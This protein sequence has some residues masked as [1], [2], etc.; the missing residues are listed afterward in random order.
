[1]KFLHENDLSKSISLDAIEKRISLSSGSLK[2]ENPDSP[3][4]MLGE[5]KTCY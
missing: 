5:D 1:M 2:Y 4:A 3:I